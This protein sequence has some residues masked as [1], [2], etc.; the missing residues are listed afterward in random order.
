MIW[1]ADCVE[2]R[3]TITACCQLGRGGK[4]WFGLVWGFLFFCVWMDVCVWWV[5]RGRKEVAGFSLLFL[6]LW[7]EGICVRVR[8]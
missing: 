5:S 3:S 8:M 1:R 6:R 7:K 2:S 4:F